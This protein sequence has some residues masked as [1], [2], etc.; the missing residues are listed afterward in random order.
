[1]CTSFHKQLYIKTYFDYSSSY[2]GVEEYTR[3]SE[4]PLGNQ[5]SRHGLQDGHGET[6]PSS[7]MFKSNNTFLSLSQSFVTRCLPVDKSSDAVEK[8]YPFPAASGVGANRQ[9]RPRVPQPV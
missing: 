4:S 5:V 2:E 1:M 8:S 3:D 6:T 9:N 7:Q